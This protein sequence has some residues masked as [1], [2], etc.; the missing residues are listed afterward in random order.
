MAG[1][2][3]RLDSRAGCE[4]KGRCSGR[5]WFAH[6]GPSDLT[7]VYQAEPY[8]LHFEVAHRRQVLAVP[9]LDGVSTASWRL[10]PGP[11]CLLHSG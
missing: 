6:L 8:R 5:I 7:V 11:S 9:E 4:L 2:Y 10:M 1:G 3:A